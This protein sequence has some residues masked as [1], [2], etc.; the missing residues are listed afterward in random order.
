MAARL[1][2]AGHDVAVW[3]RTATRTA[4]LV[5]QG[6]RT[7]GSPALAADGA[8]AAITMLASPEALEE[9][10]FGPDGLS[11]GLA[12]GTALIE[13]STVGPDAV[14]GTANRL[15]TG[16]GLLDAPVLGSV[17]QQRRAR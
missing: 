1:V 2:A 4:P 8:E 13:M 5:E 6:A 14:R 12:G 11:S 16:V 7:A 17:P 10:V 3:N 9:V 15:P